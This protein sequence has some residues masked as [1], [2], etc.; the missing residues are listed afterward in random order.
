MEKDDDVAE[1]KIM[2]WKVMMLRRKSWRKNGREVK[3]S[4]AKS[5]PSI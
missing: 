5:N 3:A 2:M 4:V 1:Q